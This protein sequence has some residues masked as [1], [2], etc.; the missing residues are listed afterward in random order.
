LVSCEHGDRR[1]AEMPL[2][3]PEQKKTLAH[4]FEGKKLNSPNDLVQK[5]SGEYY[6]TDTFLWTSG[7][8]KRWNPQKN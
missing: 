8:G 6:F 5:S 7:P 2:D 3:K 1:I 4:L